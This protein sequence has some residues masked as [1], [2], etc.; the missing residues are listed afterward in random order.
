MYRL[1]LYYLLVLW[2]TAIILGYFAILPYQPLSIIISG[3]LIFNVCLITNTIFRLVFKA[4]TNIESVYITVLILALIIGPIRPTDGAGR[5]WFLVW[6]SV[7]ATAGKYIFAIG[8][9]HIFNPAAFA[10]AL[11]ALTLSRS[12]N[13]WIGTVSM[14]PLVLAG[15]ILVVRKI[16]R[17]DLIISFLVTALAAIIGFSL[18]RGVNPMVT[19]QKTFFDSAILF[20]AFVMLTEPLTTPPTRILRIAY[21]AFV[22]FL[23]APAVHVGS[24]YSTPELALLMGNI[25]SYIVSPKAKLLLTLKDKIPVA[26]DI[27][28]FVFTPDKSLKFKPGQYLEW[29][30]GHPRTDNRGNRRYFTIASSPTEVDIRLGVKLYPDASSFKRNLF[31]LGLGDTIIASQLAG[32]FTLPKDLGKKLIFIAG[33]I[34]ITPFRS[35]IKYL[36]DQNEQRPITLFYSTKTPDEIVYKDIF[37]EAE[38]RL[39]IKTVYALTDLNSILDTW[40]G[41]RGYISESMIIKYVPDY[42]ECLFY[43]SGPRAMVVTFEDLLK[44]INVKNSSIKKDFFPGFA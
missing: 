32:D 18:L 44:K 24:L 28:D 33:G 2:F 37:D 10:V 19:V 13:W 7:W 16:M 30:L 1:V 39:G 41:E 23:F 29:T 34:G 11:T 22:G 31:S 12:A 4:Q 6:A 5:L 14:L 27:Y 20:F 21:G 43:I 35:M 42:K 3:L 26:P 17:P 40:Q 25:F 38:Q 36:I 9:K 8:K 15:G